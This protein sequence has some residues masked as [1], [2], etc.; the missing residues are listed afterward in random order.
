MKNKR[1]ENFKWLD[2]QGTTTVFL[3]NLK[4]ILTLKV[5]NQS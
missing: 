5:E 2:I 4:R 1:M 3:V